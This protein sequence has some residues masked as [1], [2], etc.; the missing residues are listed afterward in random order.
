MLIELALDVLSFFNGLNLTSFTW[1]YYLLMIGNVLVI[2]YMETPWGKS[3]V[4]RTF[5][6]A[7]STT[8]HPCGHISAEVSC[9][10]FAVETCCVLV[11]NFYL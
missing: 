8:T 11:D 1:N 5:T 2:I 4:A 7:L 10:W 6:L 3:H 9:P